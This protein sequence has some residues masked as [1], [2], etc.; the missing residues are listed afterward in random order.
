M[1]ATDAASGERK[2]QFHAPFPLLGGV[3][4]TIGRLVLFGDMGGNFYALDAA[5]GKKLWSTD[6]GGAVGG[7]VITYDTGQ[8]QKIAVAVG[9]TSP[10]WPTR[11]INGKVVVLG[12]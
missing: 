1:T 7:G 11:K 6:L 2:W 3:T 9:M 12:L 8:G 4:P 5:S 10:I